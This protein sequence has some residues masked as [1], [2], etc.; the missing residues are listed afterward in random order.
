MVLPK[1]ARPLVIEV[2]CFLLPLWQRKQPQLKAA[3]RN[4]KNTKKTQKTS[5]ASCAVKEGYM[6]FKETGQM[7]PL[8]L[9]SFRRGSLELGWTY[10]YI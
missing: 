3:R 8:V 2:S 5:A 10:V 6:K 1:R 7:N 4:K 9:A